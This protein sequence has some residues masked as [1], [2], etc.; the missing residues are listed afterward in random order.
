MH[1]PL[2]QIDYDMSD[3]EIVRKIQGIS[4]IQKKNSANV[5]FC[6]TLTYLIRKTFHFHK[7][8]VN[9]PSCLVN[10]FR[11]ISNILMPNKL[12][13]C[14]NIVWHTVRVLSDFSYICIHVF[15]KGQGLLE[16]C[17][18]LSSVFLIF[19]VVD[20]SLNRWWIYDL[21]WKWI[22]INFHFSNGNHKNAQSELI[23]I[24]RGMSFEY[25]GGYRKYYIWNLQN[26]LQPEGKIALIVCWLFINLN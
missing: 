3:H 24:K 13:K 1:K 14:R 16:K 4:L 8:S 21:Y 20:Y 17:V 18:V 19:I 26:P 6:E 9:F 23:F 10:W 12:N 15:N 25:R 7:N 5:H 2:Y 11:R 22:W